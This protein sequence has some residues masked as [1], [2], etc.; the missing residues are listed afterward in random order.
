MYLRLKARSF[1]RIACRFGFEMPDTKRKLKGFVN[2]HM[3]ARRATANFPVADIQDIVERMNKPTPQEQKAIDVI[4]AMYQGIPLRKA[5]EDLFDGSVHKFYDILESTPAI[6]EMYGRAQQSRSELMAEE[7][8]LISDTESCP[9]TARNRIDA[10]KWYASKMKP[11]KYGDKIDIT[12]NQTVDISGALAE[13]RARSMSVLPPS[14]TALPTTKQVI[15]ITKQSI[16]DA[17]DA[18][19]GGEAKK[20]TSFDEFL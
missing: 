9:Q 8:I 16:D 5:I 20:N 10:R 2:V 6:G 12:V 14:Y 19:S 17:P 13:A 3:V 15:D 7:I 4:N 1:C 18:V 11:N